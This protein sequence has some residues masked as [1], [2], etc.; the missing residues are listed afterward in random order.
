MQIVFGYTEYIEL[1]FNYVITNNSKSNNSLL[2]IDQ[3]L[4]V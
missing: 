1:I 3:A 2:D 4:K